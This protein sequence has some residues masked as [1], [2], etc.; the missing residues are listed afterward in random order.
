MP[1]FGSTCHWYVGLVVIPASTVKVAFEFSQIAEST[2]WIAISGFSSIV[3][4]AALEV[5]AGAQVPLMTAC[6]ASHS[7]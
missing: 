1:V 6:T 3:S 2:G 7:L 5:A 4:I